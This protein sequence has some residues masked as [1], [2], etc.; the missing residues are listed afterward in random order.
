MTVVVDEDYHALVA[1]D[2][3][4]QTVAMTGITPS[5]CRMKSN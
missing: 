4:Q 5:N 2:F 3:M 1:M